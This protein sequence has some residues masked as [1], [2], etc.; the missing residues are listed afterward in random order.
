[1]ARL[2]DASLD[3]EG[4]AEDEW[5]PQVRAW[6]AV[7]VGREGVQLAPMA[8]LAEAGAIGFSEDGAPIRSAGIFRS[9]LAYAGALGLPIVDHAEDA[10]LTDGAEASE[11]LVATVLGLKGWPAAAE[12][13][14]VARDLAILEDVVRDVPTARLHLTHLSLAGSLELVRAAKARGL[15]VTCD[16][17]PHHLALSDEWLAGARR[18]AWEALGDGG[19]RRDPWADGALVAEPYDTSAKVNPPLRSPERCP[20]LPP[21][22]PRRHGRCDRHRSRA[23]CQHRQGRRVRARL[24]WH[25]RDRDGTRRPARR[26]RG[27]R[28]VAHAGRPCAHGRA[29]AVLLR[30]P[31]SAAS[32]LEEGSAASIVGVRPVGRV[33]R[34][35]GRAALAR[36]ELAAA[37]SEPARPGAAHDVDGLPDLPRP[38]AGH[39]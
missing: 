39:Q 25:Q 29:G 9:A 5:H 6:A 1:M 34:H 23:A 15:P 4:V 35:A 18:W 27:G 20:R 8:E 10:T 36:Q 31:S 13:A 32:E 19:R 17:T 12:V 24:E 33:G 11:G 38:G 22:G 2:L 14:A 7:T 26:R 3:L 30:S 37:W 16:V 28:A 21:G